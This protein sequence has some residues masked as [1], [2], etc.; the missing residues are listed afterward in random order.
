LS[1]FIRDYFFQQRVSHR[2]AGAGA[3]RGD[4]AATS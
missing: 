2:A 4:A 1:A 3:P